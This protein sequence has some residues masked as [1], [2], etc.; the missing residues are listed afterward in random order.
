MR[1]VKRIKVRLLRDNYYFLIN[2]YNKLTIL[3][4]FLEF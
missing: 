3:I 2:L 1:D 4:L